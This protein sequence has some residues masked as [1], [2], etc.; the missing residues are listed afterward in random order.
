MTYTSYEGGSV[1][2]R[3][4]YDAQFTDNTKYLCRGK[5]STLKVL[6]DKDIP[7]E[8]GRTPDD[9][10]FSLKDDKT[11]TTFTITDL[12]AKD[13]GQYWCAVRRRVFETDVYRE[14]FLSVK[15]VSHMSGVKGDELSVQ[16][17]YNHV[18]NN[19]KFFCKGEN[20]SLC[21]TSGVKVSKEKVTNGRFSLIDDTSAR[22]F[23]VTITNLTEEDSGMYWCGNIALRGSQ[24]AHDNWISAVILKISEVTSESTSH[25][26]T[27][28]SFHITHPASTDSSSRSATSSSSPSSLL[29]S[30][31]SSAHSLSPNTETSLFVFI[32]PSVAAMLILFGFVLFIYFRRRKKNEQLQLS[33]VAH[34]SAGNQEN[35]EIRQTRVSVC[36]Y[37]EIPLTNVHHSLVLP[38][39]GEHDAS[40]YALAQNVSNN[41]HYSTIE[42]TDHSDRTSDGQ[43]LCDY[44]T[45]V[46]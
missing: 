37:E 4:P 12:R 24:Q 34:G 35:G 13:G 20:L 9:T 44:V 38:A 40:V 10:R 1:N 16:C 26:P 42:F 30:S 17:H 32:T 14:V 43:T 29:T 23:T 21:E 22:V 6:A 27:T 25:K 15:N 18:I 28:A 33:G 5:C 2:I 7:I 31:S 11:A 45:V 3:C 41:L 46:L 36:Y 8:T 19:H 39:S